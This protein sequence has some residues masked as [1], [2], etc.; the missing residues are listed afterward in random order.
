MIY[1][2]LRELAAEWEDFGYLVGIDDSVIKE[3]RA[4]NSNRTNCFNKVI[5]TWLK[6]SSE[7]VTKENLAKAIKA[8]GNEELAHDILGD[9][10]LKLSFPYLKKKLNPMRSKYNILGSQLGINH[11]DI[12]AW[13]VVRCD[14]SHCMNVVIQKWFEIRNEDFKPSMSVLKEALENIGKCG[15]YSDLEQKYQGKS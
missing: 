3:I 12:C 15:L 4:S 7:T 9:T 1:E 8:A 10:Q 2:D 11:Y 5:I 13:E 6:R 14:V